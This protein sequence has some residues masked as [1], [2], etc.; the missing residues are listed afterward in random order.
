MATGLEFVIGTYDE[1]ILG[2]KVV[3]TEL[4]VSFYILLR[5]LCECKGMICT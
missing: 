2:Y 3:R 4:D 5:R 1:F